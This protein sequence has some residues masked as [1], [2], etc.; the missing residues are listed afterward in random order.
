[1]RPEMG[2]RGEIPLEMK[3]EG[4]ANMEG[5][6]HWGLL[7][8]AVSSLQVNSGILTAQ[9]G[10]SD[11]HCLAP[12]SHTS[13]HKHFPFFSLGFPILPCTKLYTHRRSNCFPSTET[14]RKHLRVDAEHNN[15][16]PQV[17]RPDHFDDAGLFG[18]LLKS[19]LQFCKEAN[20]LWSELGH[21]LTL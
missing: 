18:L 16:L 10:A 9:N 6:K 14:G 4:S 11:W 3:R 8:N 5:Q 13:T 20:K 7:I 2:R 15:I 19:S 12:H 21:Y 17:P 1:M